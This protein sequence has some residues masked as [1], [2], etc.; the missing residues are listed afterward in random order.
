M[1]ESGDEDAVAGC[2]VD[3]ELAFGSAHRVAVEREPDHIPH[4]WIVPLLA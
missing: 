3:E 2:G 4:A 1:A